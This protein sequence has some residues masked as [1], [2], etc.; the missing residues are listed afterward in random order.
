MFVLETDSHSVAQAGLEPRIFL[1]QPQ[2][3]EIEFWW[4]AGMCH[5]AQPLLLLLLVLFLKLFLFLKKKII[6]L[7]LILCCLCM[8]YV[9]LSAGVD[10]G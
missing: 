2:S 9:R 4:M 10:G 5:L 7:L 1:P 8:G 3:T 6:F